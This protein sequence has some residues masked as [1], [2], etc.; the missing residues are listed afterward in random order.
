V[1]VEPQAEHHWLSKL[2]GES[3]YEMEVTEPGKSPVIFTTG[4]ET[5]RPVGDLWVVG[6]A[7]GSTTPEGASVESVITHGYDPQR[8]H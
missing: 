7:R 4:T 8:G 2:I 6:Q 1:H 5:V 3:T